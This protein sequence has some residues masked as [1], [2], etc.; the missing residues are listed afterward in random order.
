MN[1]TSLI[2]ILEIDSADEDDYDSDDNDDNDLYVSLQ[3]P[4]AL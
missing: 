4:I 3:C 1:I 2:I